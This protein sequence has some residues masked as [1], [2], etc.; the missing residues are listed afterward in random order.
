[1]LYELI[2]VVAIGY[3]K[4]IYTPSWT[5][6]TTCGHTKVRSQGCH[7][8]SAVYGAVT[9]AKGRCTEDSYYIELSL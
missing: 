1:M 8:A 7:V 4:V 5:C 9:T 6:K 2:K 3:W